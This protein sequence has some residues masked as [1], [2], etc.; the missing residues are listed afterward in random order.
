MCTTLSFCT[1]LLLSLPQLLPCHSAP[2]CDACLLDLHGCLSPAGG[3]M[4]STNPRK[5]L[6][7]CMHGIHSLCR[8]HEPLCC[9]AQ[10]CC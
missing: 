7:L 4:A 6:R 8:L 2:A 9:S 1:L 3:L 5:S 10:A